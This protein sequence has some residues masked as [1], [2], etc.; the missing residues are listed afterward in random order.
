MVKELTE[1]D[2]QEIIN[3]K[4][5]ECSEYHDGTCLEFAFN[6]FKIVWKNSYKYYIPIYLIPLI[7][8]KRK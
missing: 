8:F 4:F 2:V 1:T 5:L 6:R 7:L 3:G